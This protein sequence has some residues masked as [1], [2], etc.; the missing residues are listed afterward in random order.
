MEVRKSAE[1]I[2]N[3]IG[4]VLKRPGE[5]KWNSLYDSLTQLSENKVKLTDIRRVL[6]VRN[7][8][9][10]NDFIY[11]EE[12]VKC[13]SLIA[14]AIDILQEERDIFY[15]TLLLC[16]FSLRRKL[17]ILTKKKWT[18]FG[19]LSVQLLLSLKMRFKDQYLTP[20]SKTGG[21]PA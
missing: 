1:E 2:E 13:T 14:E 21:S 10:E 18:F 5:T 6:G 15:E 11:I 19:S 7:I 17:Q 9:R 16:L 12:H 4:H 20:I 8:L 3:I